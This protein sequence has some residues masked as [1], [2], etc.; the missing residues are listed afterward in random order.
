[1]EVVIDEYDLKGGQDVV[2]FMERLKTDTTITHVL[3]LS[4][5][6]YERKADSREKGVGMEA[7]ILSFDVYQDIGQ[8]RVVPVLMELTPEGKPCLPTFLRSR[9]YFDFS[10]DAE[11]HRNW[12]KLT[13]HLWNK[14]IRSKPEVGNPPRYLEETIGGSF[15]ATKSTWMAL[16]L[17]LL[18]GKPS[19]P[20]LREELLDAVEAEMTAAFVPAASYDGEDL[21][22]QWES[23]VRI[24]DECRS[25]LVEWQLMESRLDAEAAVFKCAIPM[26]ERINSFPQ[27]IREGAG[28]PPAVKD[29]M[30]IFG[31]EMALYVVACLIEV[32]APEALRRLLAHPFP[33]RGSYKHEHQCHLSGF[34]HHSD[35]A[36]AWNNK[37]DPRWISPIAKLILDRSSHPKIDKIRLCQAE[38]LIFLVNILNHSSWYPST[39]VHAPRGTRFAWFLKAKAGK[40]PDRL[41]LVTGLKDWNTVQQQFSKRFKEATSDSYW[42]VFRAGSGSYL[43]KMSL[44]AAG[45][46]L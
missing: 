7:Q 15:V 6:N 25:V 46:S 28:I 37:Q 11:M 10:S 44:D 35:Y 9:Y 39:S 8:T 19:V 24:P 27:P 40:Q 17:A 18:E 38:A 13:R 43:E 20:V 33:D 14:P 4:D 42:Q 45:S 1:M 41:A 5:S 29:A 30:A 36:E 23:C 26:L 12:E 34:Y 32:D 3:V 31:Y 22:A 2:A 21:L 16:R